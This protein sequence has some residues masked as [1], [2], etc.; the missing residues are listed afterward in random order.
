MQISHMKNHICKI[1]EK[2]VDI[3]TSKNQGLQI[4][5]LVRSLFIVYK[6]IM[7]QYYT[8]IPVVSPVQES[9][10]VTVDTISK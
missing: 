8:F 7:I 10:K 4:L 5:Y 6:Y 1:Q 3:I 2:Q 9:R